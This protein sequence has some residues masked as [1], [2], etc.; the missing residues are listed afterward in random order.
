MG[1]GRALWV[2]WCC[3]WAGVW[4]VLGFVFVL[5]WLLVPF[6]LLA[7][8]LPVGRRAPVVVVSQAQAIERGRP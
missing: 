8:L 1:T 6:S 5:P 7:V 4:T 3:A 2:I